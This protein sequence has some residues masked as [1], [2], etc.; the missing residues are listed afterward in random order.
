MNKHVVEKTVHDIKNSLGVILAR[1]EIL[2][3]QAAKNSLEASS[4]IVSAESIQAQVRIIRTL[5]DGID[6]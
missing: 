6:A 4:V 1:A 2:S 3:L 5:V